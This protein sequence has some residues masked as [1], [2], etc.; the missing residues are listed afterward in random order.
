MPPAQP[1]IGRRQL[2]DLMGDVGR[3]LPSF[4]RE[5]FNDRVLARQEQPAPIGR[6]LAPDLVARPL[7]HKSALGA[8]ALDQLLVFEK[9]E[10]LANGGASNSAFGGKVVYGRNLLTRRP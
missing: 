1:A 2:A 9:A 6:D 8:M 7:Q 5:N 4:V 10:R 3:L